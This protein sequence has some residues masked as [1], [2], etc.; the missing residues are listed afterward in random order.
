LLKNI[1]FNFKTKLTTDDKIARINITIPYSHIHFK[2]VVGEKWAGQKMTLSDSHVF[3][4]ISKAVFNLSM[5]AN[6][7]S[8]RMIGTVFI[9]LERSMMDFFGK[10]RPSWNFFSSFAK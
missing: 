2:K 6:F 4:A 10:K 5:L 8:N 7:Q 9:G 3:I 1:I